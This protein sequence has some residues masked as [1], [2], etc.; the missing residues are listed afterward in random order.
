MTDDSGEPRNIRDYPRITLTIRDQVRRLLDA[1]AEHENRSPWR[2]VESAIQGYFEGLKVRDRRAI[3]ERLGG[4]VAPEPENIQIEIPRSIEK[5]VI[6]FVRFWTRPKDDFEDVT[7]RFIAGALDL[8][9]QERKKNGG[10][11][12]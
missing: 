8:P 6:A 3:Q 7:R 11:A 1:I 4:N 5:A 9:L 2:V 10:N 12:H